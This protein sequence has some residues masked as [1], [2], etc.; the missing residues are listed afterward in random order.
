MFPC[1]SH[2]RG[3]SSPGDFCGFG[4]YGHYFPWFLLLQ[5]I[6]AFFILIAVA[7]LLIKLF[8]RGD[9][10]SSSYKKESTMSRVEEVNLEALR[11]LNQRYINKEISD[12]EY[13]RMKKSILSKPE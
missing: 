10:M 13:L 4:V 8:K 5:F 11:Q 9:L 1:F 12:E 3:F 6:V 7:Y 2:M